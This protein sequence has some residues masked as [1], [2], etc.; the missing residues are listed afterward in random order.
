MRIRERS[1]NFLWLVLCGLLL[2]PNL[3]A[4]DVQEDDFELAKRALGI[5]GVDLANVPNRR[6]CSECHEID[7]FNVRE[8][9]NKSANLMRICFFGGERLPLSDLSDAATKI[10]CMR[11]DR[12]DPNS[13]FSPGKMGFQAAFAHTDFYK[14]FFKQAYPTDWEGKYAQFREQAG[15]PKNREPL[16]LEDAEVLKSWVD[17]GGPYLEKLLANPQPAPSTCT[18]FVDNALFNHLDEMRRYGWE[19]RNKAERLRMFGCGPNEEKTQCFRQIDEKGNAI[20]VEPKNTTFGKDWTNDFPQ[21]TM[22]ILRELPLRTRYW[23]RSSPDG[24]FVSNGGSWVTDLQTVLNGQPD[25]DIKVM[26]QYDPEFFPDN[27]G[28]MF[29]DTG[30]SRDETAFCSRDILADESVTAIDFTDQRC[31]SVEGGE[32]GL[33]QAVGA[34]LG[35]GDYLAVFG[36]FASNSG[37]SIDPS[38]DPSWSENSYLHMVTLVNDGTVYKPREKVLKWTP[39]EGDW[40]VSPST[41]M[42]ISRVA[43]VQNGQR[44]Q[45]GYNVHLAKPFEVKGRIDYRVEKVGTFCQNGGKGKS[46]FDE[47]M[48]AFFHYVG[49]ADFKE[50][51]FSSATDPKFKSL[52][53]SSNIYVHDLLTGVTKRVTRMG[54]NQQALFPHFRSDGWMYFQMWDSKLNK[55]YIVA[56]DASIELE[57]SKLK[58][59][60]QDSR[61]T[62]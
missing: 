27:S 33:Y 42:L 15:M 40:N 4:R 36:D 17:K 2:G 20:F 56:S 25:R 31:N 28:F 29:Q 50:M 47:R 62:L 44:V 34:D 23:M 60:L 11:K 53:G 55:R 21:G 10:N 19:T 37:N 48:F 43:G 59:H 51:G 12:K 30:M 49:P 6:S 13:D 22:H 61:E 14:G 32:V 57:Q 9:I 16:S 41:R 3:Y 35:S 24:R 58:Q 8:W 46:S 38:E 5:I 54:P 1:G 26:A 7:I 18:P 39:Y 52:I 45:L